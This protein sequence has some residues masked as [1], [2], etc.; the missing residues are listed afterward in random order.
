MGWRNKT[1]KVLTGKINASRETESEWNFN[2]G[3]S[4]RILEKLA[5]MPVKL[6]DISHLFVGLQT[7]ADDVYILE[8]I[9][10]DKDKVLCRSKYTG[11][12]HWFENK[13]LKPFLKGSL[14]IRRYYLSD[15]TKRLIFP[16]TTKKEKSILINPK[17][18]Q[19][20]FPLTWNYLNECMKRLG[21]RNKGKIGKDWYGYVYKK[22]HT[23]FNYPKLLVPSIATGS[24]FAADIEGN[25][26]FVG[27]GGGGGGGYGITLL[28]ETDLSYFYVLGVLNS[29]LLSTYLKSI[30]TSFQGGYIALNRQYIE[31]LPIFSIN[32]S[33]SSEKAQHK[34]MVSLVERMLDLHKQNPKTPQEQEMVKREI[35]STDKQIDSLVYELYGLT[36]EEINIVEH[37]N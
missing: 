14:N 17:E 12:D 7:D 16:Y 20:K 4:S 21:S 31:Q 26:F 15:V 1:L 37:N 10:H 2:V 9:R 22:N 28:P 30:S 18:Y 29:K 34:K 36:E 13:H 3:T 5:K 23:R 35:D 32:F 33:D 8:E 11:E 27:S 25:Y 24:C 6:G 19:S